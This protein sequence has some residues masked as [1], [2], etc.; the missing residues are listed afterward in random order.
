MKAYWRHSQFKY[1]VDFR[2]N[3]KK[4]HLKISTQVLKSLNRNI[5]DYLNGQLNM[6]QT[7][8]IIVC[9]CIKITLTLKFETTYKFYSLEWR[10]QN[11]ATLTHCSIQ[12][13]SNYS[14]KC[15]FGFG[16]RSLN[17]CATDTI[18]ILLLHWPYVETTACKF[19]FN[20]Y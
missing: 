1:V 9:I 18:A 15:R 7:I 6:T 16:Y 13:R 14:D 10:T 17:N 19:H 8:N 4:Q 5:V 12:I 3:S 20:S 2:P 11:I